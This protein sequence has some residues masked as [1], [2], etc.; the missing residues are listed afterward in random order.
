MSGKEGG[1]ET[2]NADVTDDGEI[3]LRQPLTSSGLEEVGRD[4]LPETPGVRLGL[5]GRWL[6]G[7]GRQGAP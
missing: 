6:G 4:E 2:Y 5:G 1:D 3:V 7:Q